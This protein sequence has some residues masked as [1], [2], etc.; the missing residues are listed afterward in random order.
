MV[1]IWLLHAGVDLLGFL[2]VLVLVC[3]ADLLLVVVGL[4]FVGFS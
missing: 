4:R 3:I 2:A 1:G